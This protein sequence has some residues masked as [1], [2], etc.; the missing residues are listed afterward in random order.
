MSFIDSSGATWPVVP[1]E[2]Q[3]AP[4]RALCVT[5]LSSTTD[6]GFAT[7]VLSNGEIVT[8]WPIQAPGGAF[9]YAVIRAASAT[10]AQFVSL[11][12][13][14]GRCRGCDRPISEISLDVR[15]KRILV[16]H[17]LD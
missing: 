16:R 6:S 3:L 5:R 8:F 4:I 9:A 17:L 11:T 13:G 15:K 7:L 10:G 2:D 12:N 1:A 14:N